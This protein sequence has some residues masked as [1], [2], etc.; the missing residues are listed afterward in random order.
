M[1]RAV[2]RLNAVCRPMARNLSSG[3]GGHASLK[4]L[5]A[6]YLRRLSD[7]PVPSG[8]W[9]EY[10]AKQNSLWNMYLVAGALLFASGVG[11][12]YKD[13]FWRLYTM[14]DLSKFKYP[15]EPDGSCIKN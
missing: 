5:D 7:L 10:H 15:E 9:S 12:M 11:A 3:H 13:G 8:S 4:E 2:T 14:P 6:K 1:Q